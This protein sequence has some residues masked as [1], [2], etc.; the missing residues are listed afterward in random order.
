MVI[1]LDDD[2]DFRLALAANLSDDGYSVRHY[3]RPA[4]VPPLLL[5]EAVTILILDFEMNGE[6]GLSFAD[7]F[8]A[9]HPDVPV[10]MLTAYWSDF[11][12]REIGARDFIV[13]RR[14]PVDYEEL[15]RLLPPLAHH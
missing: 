13:L 8:H 5:E 6:D 10:V 11:L 1:L 2:D 9:F 15:A 3:A 7:R 14:K 12:D 4:D